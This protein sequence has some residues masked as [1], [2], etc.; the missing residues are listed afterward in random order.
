MVVCHVKSAVLDLLSIDI[1]P[2]E[3][4]RICFHV[5]GE[6]A[7][8]LRI[9]PPAPDL[10]EEESIL[11]DG[12]CCVTWAR[13]LTSAGAPFSVVVRP[14]TYPSFTTSNRTL[15]GNVAVATRCFYRLD[16]IPIR[17]PD[18]PDAERNSC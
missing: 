3:V 6:V 10:Y 9:L 8:L 11:Q 13:Y 5:D 7:I 17:D 1:R 15:L 4:R 14:Q 18:G 12:D 2:D 16:W